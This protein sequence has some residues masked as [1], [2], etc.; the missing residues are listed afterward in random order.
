MTFT[1]RLSLSIFHT[2]SDKKNLTR[3]KAGYEATPAP[4]TYV[5]T[6]V[7]AH[8]SRSS[9]VPR[10]TLKGERLQSGSGNETSLVPRRS[11][12]PGPGIDFNRMTRLIQKSNV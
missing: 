7:H 2:V 1:S 3:G 5:R 9:L 4:R 6:Y 12:W 11:M 10:P 8:W